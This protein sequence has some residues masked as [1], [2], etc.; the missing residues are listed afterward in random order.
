MTHAYVRT[1]PPLVHVMTHRQIDPR[2]A[3]IWTNDDVFLSWPLWTKL[4]QMLIQTPTIKMIHFSFSCNNI[5]ISISLYFLPD[6]ITVIMNPAH[7]VAFYLPPRSMCHRKCRTNTNHRS[8]TLEMFAAPLK[9]ITRVSGSA[10]MV[11]ILAHR[12]I[13]NPAPNHWVITLQLYPD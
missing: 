1:G 10:S 3:V 4:R 9:G 12:V 5:A 11:P 8:M 13:N 6:T 7:L 2:K